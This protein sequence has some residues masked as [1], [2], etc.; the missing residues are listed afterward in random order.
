MPGRDA[1]YELKPGVMLPSFKYRLYTAPPDKPT[2]YIMLT[3]TN[4]RNVMQVWMKRKPKERPGSTDW[5]CNVQFR[6]RPFR[7]RRGRPAP[8]PKYDKVI[9]IYLEERPSSRP[10]AASCTLEPVSIQKT[11]GK[12]R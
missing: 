10:E 1:K 4:C 8:G 5:S 6:S 11:E 2:G 12:L 3:C 9:F 7:Q